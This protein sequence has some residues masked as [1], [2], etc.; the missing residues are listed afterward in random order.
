M[1]VWAISNGFKKK[2]PHMLIALCGCMMQEEKVVEKIR[3]SYP[4]VDL[5]FGT[6]NIFKFAELTVQA[7]ESG[8]MVVDIWEGTDQI[9]EQLPNKR[10]FRFKSGVNIMFGWQ[11]FLQLLYRSLCAGAGAQPQAGGGSSVRSG[12]LWRTGVVEVML[13]GTECEFLW[14]E[15]GASGD[16]LRSF[17]EEIEKIDGLER[18]RFM[19]SHPKD[20]SD[21][22]IAVMAGSKKICKH[23]HLPAAVRQQQTV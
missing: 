10:K 7:M 4:F 3:R 13:F 6:H 23:L 17:W 20:L 15:P 12:S 21:E 14:K 22:L 11:Q 8:K 5:V 1:A 18:I 19:T 2:N 16:V 9:V